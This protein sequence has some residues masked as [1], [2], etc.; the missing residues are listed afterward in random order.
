MDDIDIRGRRLREIV[1][2][3]RFWDVEFLLRNMDKEMERLEHGLDHVIWDM[4]GRAVTAWPRPLP[5]APKF[6]VDSD[7]QDFRVRISLPGIPKENVTI[8]VDADSVEVLACSDDNV[9][10]PYYLE[11]S[12]DAPLRPD[13]A[14]AEFSEGVLEISVSKVRRVRIPVR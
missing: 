12:S 11:I 4:D 5:L 13:T 6:K 1:E 8:N 10:R 14:R 9:C 3:S 7:E 2:Q